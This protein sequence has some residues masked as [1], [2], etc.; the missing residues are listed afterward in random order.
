MQRP[1]KLDTTRNIKS[2]YTN[3]L[4]A[5]HVMIDI[6]MVA[7]AVHSQRSR[8]HKFRRNAALAC[9]LFSRSPYRID[10]LAARHMNIQRMQGRA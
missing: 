9:S 10:R 7:Y 2:K 3:C 8:L 6:Q 1:S 5:Q 4:Q